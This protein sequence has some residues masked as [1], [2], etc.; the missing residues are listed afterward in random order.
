MAL[1]DVAV[2]EHRGATLV[3][4]LMEYC[5]GK[6]VLITARHQTNSFR[7]GS[8]VDLMNQRLPNHFEEKEILSMFAQVSVGLAVLHYMHPPLIHRDIKVENVLV[9]RDRRFKLCDFG[10]STTRVID[11][12]TAGAIALADEEIQKFTTLAYRAPEM[13]DLYQKQVVNE[14]VDI[15]VCLLYAVLP[16]FFFS[17]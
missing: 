13:V 17:F 16:S 11:N 5:P 2:Y 3:Q 1:V 6:C 9:G 10:S 7:P 8:I 4:I 15:W 12:F 14:K